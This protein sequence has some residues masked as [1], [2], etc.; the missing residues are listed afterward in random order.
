M[1]HILPGVDAPYA[2]MTQADL[3]ALAAAGQSTRTFES[4]PT[5]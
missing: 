4:K 3:N 5:D 1:I 2:L